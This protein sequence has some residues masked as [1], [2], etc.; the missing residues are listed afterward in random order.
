MMEAQ[1]TEPAKYVIVSDYDAPQPDMVCQWVPAKRYCYL[2]RTRN[3]PNHDGMIG[4]EAT[5]IEA[6]GFI[7]ANNRDGTVSFYRT[8]QPCTATYRDGV[9]R[10]WQHP[11]DKSTHKRLHKGSFRKVTTPELIVED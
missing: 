6:F 7:W 8:V 5:P 2:D 1:M 9:A 10:R 11:A 4:D 3:K